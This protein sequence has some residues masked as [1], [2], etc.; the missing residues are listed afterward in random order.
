MAILCGLAD[1]AKPVR[2]SIIYE[3]KV[4]LKIFIYAPLGGRAIIIRIAVQSA[5]VVAVADSE[6]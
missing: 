6:K 5:S 3:S 2:S 4:V 1:R